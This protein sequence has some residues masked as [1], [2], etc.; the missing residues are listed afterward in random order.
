MLDTVV[1]WVLRFDQ[2]FSV[3]AERCGRR[4][5]NDTITHSGSVDVNEIMATLHAGMSMRMSTNQTRN[6]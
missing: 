4:R 1:Y 6:S 3:S 2:Y 5:L